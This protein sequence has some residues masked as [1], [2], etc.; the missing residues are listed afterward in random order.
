MPVVNPATVC[1]PASSSTVW[2]GD[3]ENV[4]AGAS[5]TAMT[6]M[7]TVSVSVS[8]PGLPVWPRSSVTMVRV[9]AP[10]ASAGCR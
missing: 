6:V 8:G 4:K 1:G 2:S 3:A 9:S 7:A 10:L 5:F